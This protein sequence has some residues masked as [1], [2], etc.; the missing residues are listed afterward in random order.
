MGV[1]CLAVHALDAGGFAIISGGDDHA[2]CLAEIKA[3]HVVEDPVENIGVS[4]IGKLR[5]ETSPR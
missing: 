5:R 1:L 3:V 4:T 2:L